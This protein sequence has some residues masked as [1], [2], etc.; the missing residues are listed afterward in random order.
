MYTVKEKGSCVQ[1]PP[2]KLKIKWCVS[3]YSNA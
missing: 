1:I 3:K 2:R